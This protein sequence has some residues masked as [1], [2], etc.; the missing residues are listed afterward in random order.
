LIK[1]G[2]KVYHVYNGN[3]KGIVRELHATKSHYHLGAGSASGTVY[4]LLEVKGSSQLV[5]APL[6]DLMRDD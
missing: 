5:R 1:V 2:D 6:G 3:I 4:A